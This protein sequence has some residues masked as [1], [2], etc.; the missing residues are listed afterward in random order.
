[1]KKELVSLFGVAFVVAVMATGIFYGLLV[2]K[3]EQAEK[4]AQAAPAQS[5]Q[6]KL[7]EARG[8][9]EGALRAIPPGLRALS[10]H[11]SDSAGVVGLLRPGLKVDVQVVRT[12][13]PEAELR[14]VL[15]NVE[16]LNLGSA[17]G[18]R[19]VV[20]VLL[21][22]EDADLAGLADS[23]ARV[24]LL[25]RNPEDQETTKRPA[26]WLPLRPSASDARGPDQTPQAA[27]R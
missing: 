11:V 24:R 1:M 19:P 15:Q 2:G 21:K 25:L 14:T 10:L 18:G 9:P 20:N 3:L 12:L 8:T 17:E 13:G 4:K 26:V 23:T 7:A 5:P 6:Q 22:P 27:R 16:V